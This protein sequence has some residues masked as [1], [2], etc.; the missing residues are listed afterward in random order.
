MEEGIRKRRVVRKKLEIESES[1]LVSL[2]STKEEEL[3]NDEPLESQT[4]KMETYAKDLKREQ[5]ES[6]N[7]ELEKNIERMKRRHKS[8]T[9]R[10]KWEI[11]KSSYIFS[12]KSLNTKKI[13]V[14]WMSIVF[15]FLFM[16]LTLNA[17]SNKLLINVPAYGGSWNEGI[18]GVPRYINPV[19]ASSG[20]DKDLTK[21]VFAGL[22]RKDANGTLIND[23][24]K[25]VEK[26][27]DGL[28][29]TV[30]LADG[31]EFQD[32]VNL[33]ADDVIFTIEKI[34]DKNIN[35]PLGINFEGVTVDKIDDTTIVFHLKKPYTYFEENLTFGI[36][37]K[38]LLE[39]LSNEEFLMSEFNINPVGSGPYKINKISKEANVAKEYS[40]VSNRKYV[41]GRPFI[42]NLNIF[43][44]QN[45]EDLLR[46][47]NNGTIEATAYLDQTYFE[48]I[49][50]KERVIL[51]S[52]LPNIFM[53]SFNPNK[54]K[55]LSSKKVRLFL[56][57]S[58]DKDTIVNNIFSGYAT[59]KDSLFGD[60]V[61][62]FSPSETDLEAP[63]VDTEI[64]I[65][66]ADIEDLKK[67]AD[68]VA[69]SWRAQG[70]KVNIVVYSL[71]ELA[72]VIKNRNF[73]VLLFGSIVEKDIDLFA[74]WHSSQRA[75]PGLNIT[76]YA[77]TN[78]DNNLNTLKNVVDTEERKKALI[79]I[80][81]ELAREMPA[82]PLYSNN[83]NYIV[84]DESI[85]VMLQNKIPVSMTNSSERF[86]NIYDWYKSEESVWKFTYKRKLIEKLSNI[87]H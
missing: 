67:V 14:F 74:Y 20:P 57:N 47:L 5:L 12:Y 15:G 8:S 84:K 63:E 78:L 37:P 29:Y 4:R 44:Y 41:T 50:N 51:Q 46:S 2:N 45:N 49:D 60:E 39:K 55:A 62:L 73:E 79:E 24:A 69:K 13:L 66:T 42:D 31:V 71:N 7:I 77:S 32:G 80:S 61:S 23:M 83:L 16:F 40:F 76:N 53:L 33:T 1:E 64:N 72:D 27:E 25:S 22:L 35:S 65:T 11:F 54:N 87:L 30:T 3:V 56:E 85:R 70:I 81:E 17:I 43:I 59:K 68:E 38:H 9:F 58:I 6:V 86:I 28:T 34:Q 52:K 21:L 75:Y 26:D 36:L 18:M 48:N 10:K 82:I 19:L